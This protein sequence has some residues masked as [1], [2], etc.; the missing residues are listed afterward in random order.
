MIDFILIQV[1]DL[2]HVNQVSVKRVQATILDLRLM[3]EELRQGK[4]VQR[5]VEGLILT[6]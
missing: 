2:L 6:D 3:L 5:G 4:P 1:L